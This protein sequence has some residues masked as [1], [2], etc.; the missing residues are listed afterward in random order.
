[1]QNGMQTQIFS[2]MKRT[3]PLLWLLPMLVFGIMLGCEEEKDA[4][5]ADVAIN[6]DWV[7]VDQ[8]M[9]DF[10]QALRNNPAVDPQ[11]AFR[12]HLAPE[13]EFLAE[14][15]V[16]PRGVQQSP[17]LRDSLLAVTLAATLTDSAFFS[18]LDTVQARFP[19]DFDFQR[20]IAPPLKRLQQYFPDITIPAFRTHVNGYPPRGDWRMVDRVASYPGYISFGLHYFMGPDWPMYP[21]GIFAYQRRRLSPE[22]LEV[23]LV[24]EIANQIVAPVPRSAATPLLHYVMHAGIK[25][26]L[27]QRLLPYTPDSLLLRYTSD[28]MAWANLYEARNY[29]YLM[30]KFYDTDFK[31]ERDYLSDKAYTTDLALESAPRLGEY[32]GWKVVEAYMEE[33][34]ETTL[35]ELCERQDYEGMLRRSRYKP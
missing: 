8:L 24:Q 12:E 1:M 16:L 3:R 18:L 20:R 17:R 27:M 33:H 34:P 11:I 15:V 2:T 4:D 22:Y 7:R 6:L 35:A 25:Q 30:P 9:Y 14:Y 26:Y 32:I 10:A 23:A 13:A 5:V 28:Q 19:D 29:K 21:A 31:L